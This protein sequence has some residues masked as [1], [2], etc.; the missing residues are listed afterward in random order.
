M[1]ALDILRR[2]TAQKRIRTIVERTDKSELLETVWLLDR[3][4]S[5]TEFRCPRGFNFPD[6]LFG[7]E[8]NEG[9]TVFGWELESL[10]NEILCWPEKPGCRRG[11]IREWQLTRR[12]VNALRK[13]ENYEYATNPKARI[14]REIDRIGYRQF[15]WQPKN[16][17]GAKFVRWW[18]IIMHSNLADIFADK[19]GT[20]VQKFITLGCA[21]N[22]ILNE[23]PF[24]EMV[25][26]TDLPAFTDEDVAA[27][28]RNCSIP[29][30]QAIV[31]ARDAKRQSSSVAYVRGVLR[32]RPLIEVRRR[33]RSLFIRP[34]ENLLNWRLSSGLYYDVIGTRDSARLIGEAFEKYV[35][36][37]FREKFPKFSI[38]GEFA[39][40][41]KKRPKKSPDVLVTQDRKI[42]ILCEC[43]SAKMSFNAQYQI[44][45][46]REK[47]RVVEEIA[48]GVVQ[49]CT[50]ELDSSPSIRQDGLVLDPNFIPLVVTLDDFV[51]FGE[52]GR[53]QVFVKAREMAKQKGIESKRLDDEEVLLCTVGELEFV[54]T[55]FD[56]SNMVSLMTKALDQ[57]YNQTALSGVL[58]DCNLPKLE[59]PHHPLAFRLDDIFD[60]CLR[61]A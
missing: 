1:S 33:G 61:A 60:F 31:E 18:S 21:W 3:A 54:A 5:D 53:K 23:N 35:Q 39:Y 42:M 51:F 22:L 14:F 43:K 41:S 11:N 16:W 59:D 15:R 17:Q 8:W 27:F 50:F 45:S 48:K 13:L 12:L 36:D 47:E 29:L 52:E 10:T 6:E 9:I 34:M 55:C 25:G 20:S 7:T 40:G 46:E 28:L 26:V 58:V 57:K 44:G 37:I 38:E 56:Q 49:L 2:N 32:Q 24:S 19:V 30:D 4:W